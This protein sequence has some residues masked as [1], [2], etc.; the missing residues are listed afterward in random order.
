MASNA[1]LASRTDLAADARALLTEFVNRCTTALAS[2][3]GPALS[4]LR[5]QMEATLAE[6][7]APEELDLSWTGGVTHPGMQPGPTVVDLIDS[8]RRAYALRLD[9]EMRDALGMML[10]DPPDPDEVAAE[11]ADCDE[12]DG[13][14][15]EDV[16]AEALFS[17]LVNESDAWRSGTAHQVHARS[18]P[19][20]LDYLLA[21]GPLRADENKALITAIRLLHPERFGPAT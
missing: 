6:L 11:N 1:P 18:D 13:P 5:D 20:A 9:D 4:I 19:D 3:E 16:T 2:C 7:E 15:L 17:Y 14:L 12:Q 10:V 21:R 8:R